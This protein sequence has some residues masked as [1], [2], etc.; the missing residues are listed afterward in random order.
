MQMLYRARRRAE[1]D[2]NR[3]FTEY[4]R[5]LKKGEPDTAIFAV[6]RRELRAT[7]RNE[8]RR[9]GIWG[10]P[11]FY[12]GVPGWRTWE[13]R[14]ETGGDAL[15][16]L[17]SDCYSFIFL[18]RLRSLRE[19]LRVNP[20]IEGLV[21]RAVRHFVHERQAKHDPI[22]AQVYAVLRSAVEG[23]LAA[24]EL[25]LLRGG[26][27][28]GNDTI[29]G[30]SAG[31]QP[32]P[33]AVDLRPLVARWNDCL[34]PGI[35]ILRGRRQDEVVRRLQELLQ[36]L[37]S[38]GAEAF[39][40]KDL[41]D[42]LKADVRARWAA[43]FETEGGETGYEEGEGDEPRKVALVLP[44]L[45]VEEWQFL[46]KVVACVLEAVAGFEANDKMRR[47]LHDLWQFQRAAAGMG[48]GRSLSDRKLE[49]LLEI[50]RERIPELFEILG[51]F[52]ERCR[53][54]N[55]GKLAVICL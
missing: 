39:R 9:R 14:T 47:Y 40:F 37:R 27:R 19:Y 32:E 51:R 33:G 31:A 13:E 3:V 36:E 8:L 34:V 5:A 54:A 35:V 12:V 10:S 1:A 49:K 2:S 18:D 30:F 46:R 48:E 7:L 28:I 53:A 29:L 16:E 24:G 52:L 21:V 43:V 45:E 22:G 20:G 23:A 4:V 15:D 11:P 26:E 17:C 50:P 38:E 44:D 25:H 42:P 41:I 6:L 55:L